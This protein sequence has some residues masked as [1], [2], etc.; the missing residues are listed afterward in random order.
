MMNTRHAKVLSPFTQWLQ[1]TWHKD[2]EEVPQKIYW[3]INWKGI[4]HCQEKIYLP[5]IP[6]S[7]WQ[8]CTWCRV[9]LWCYQSPEVWFEYYQPC[10][11]ASLHYHRSVL[12]MKQMKQI[13]RLIQNILANL[14]LSLIHQLLQ[15]LRLSSKIDQVKVLMKFCY[16]I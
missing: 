5:G 1:N 9:V 2:G 10:R 11:N 3:Q 7:L 14:W 16:T 15:M 12:M 4:F 13:V 6:G 8:W